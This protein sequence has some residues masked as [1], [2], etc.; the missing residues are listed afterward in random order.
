MLLLATTCKE[1]KTYIVIRFSNVKVKFIEDNTNGETHAS[2]NENI[3]CRLFISFHSGN[4]SNKKK[5]I[6]EH[7]I[8]KKIFDSNFHEFYVRWS[9]FG[10]KS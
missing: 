7:Q 2:F 1:K 3:F 6:N 9:I 10:R 5:L 4:F 8:I